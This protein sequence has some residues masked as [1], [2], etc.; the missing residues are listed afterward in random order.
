MNLMQ[1][2]RNA[3][4]AITGKSNAASA[5][6]SA[7]VRS[8]TALGIWHES[9]NGFVPREVNP[10]LYEALREAIAPID[11]GIIRTV[12]LDGVIRVR[13]GNEKLVSV[14]EE[15]L[16]ANL[17]VNDYEAGLQAFYA[18]QGNEIY[19]QGFSVGEMIL[20]AA[21]RELIGLRVADSKGI[22]YRRNEAH[23]ME[24]WYRP[25][26]P[27]R[28]GRRDGTDQMEAVIRNQACRTVDWLNQANYVL[29]D[30]PLL[31]YAACNPEAAGP[32]GVSVMR[33]MEFV[34]Q[35]LLKIQ[36]ASGHVWDRFGDPP[37]QLTYKTSNRALKQ[38]DLDKRRLAL[39]AELEKVI[40]AKR[41]GNSADFV[42]AVGKDDDITIKAIGADGQVIEIEMPARHMMEQILAKLGLPPWMLGLSW[43][44]SE[45][46]ADQQSEMALQESRT[47]FERRL[48]G[49]RKIVATWL[50]GRGLTWKPGDWQLYQE[51]PRLSDMLKEAQADFLRAQTQ[52]ML[53]GTAPPP[54]PGT[55]VGDPRKSAYPH[56]LGSMLPGLARRRAAHAHARKVATDEAEPWAETD[57][58]L[59][60]I[61]ARA[62]AGLLALW[63]D[64]RDRVLRALV[65][66]SAKAAKAPE[67]WTFDPVGL[68]QLLADEEAI[69]LAAAG[70]EQGPLL[71]EAFRAWVRG[72]TNAALAFDVPAAIEETHAEMR[73]QLLA[74]GLERVRT[75][76]ARTLRDDILAAL[77]GGDFD[78]MNPREV[79]RRLAERFDV[80]DYDWER[81]ARSE[82][83]HAQALGKRAQYL[84]MA[85]Q[86]LD[87][88][89][90]GDGYCPI[91]AD[92]AAAGPYPI[93][94]APMPVDDSHPNC[95][96][97]VVASEA[98]I[99]GRGVG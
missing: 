70:G 23:A 19:E 78:G 43:S 21:G 84:A 49:L 34:G 16:M 35:V 22:Y 5:S 94:T 73:E 45:R 25:P 24:T 55:G 30:A 44:T 50:R 91:C 54:P 41:S 63:G 31:V 52:M 98:D 1:K 68:L 42:Q 10:Y 80:H 79:A 92:L 51:L 36:N 46:M 61:E 28:S 99:A 48:P 86:E 58:E 4:A 62:I 96:C 11:G 8:G 71:Q 40:S 72:L 7:L 39:A 18:S 95:R 13:G 15:G 66:P 69:F 74:R 27:K 82:I 77:T 87:W 81:L 76:L 17:P 75:A 65:L 97:S 59:P 89:T 38:E 6:A 90:A 2:I 26:A 53:S 14:I 64:L 29:L 60:R 9:L 37:L 85:V 3:G 20:D 32:Y 57:P 67:V 88:L 83:A 12:T 47:R 33:S 56:D 93:L